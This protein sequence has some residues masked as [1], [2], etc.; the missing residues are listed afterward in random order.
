MDALPHVGIQ[1]AVREAQLPSSRQLFEAL[2]TVRHRPEGFGHEWVVFHGHGVPGVLFLQE[3]GG[4][5]V[6]RHSGSIGSHP[7]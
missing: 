6:T 4:G 2:R 1:A 3:K 7:S 5:L